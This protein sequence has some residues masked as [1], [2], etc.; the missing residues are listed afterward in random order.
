VLEPA[1]AAPPTDFRAL[2]P[3]AMRQAAKLCGLSSRDASLM[4]LFATAVYHLPKAD[5]AARVA[6]VTS[7]D[8]VKQLVSRG[9]SCLTV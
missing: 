8:I 9:V 5:A 7:T 3:L 2:A 1:A 4:R 6:P